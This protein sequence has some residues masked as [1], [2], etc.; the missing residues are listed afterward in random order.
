MTEANPEDRRGHVGAPPAYAP[1]VDLDRDALVSN[2][3]AA[4]RETPEGV[5]DARGGGW[6][7]GTAFVTRAAAE[8]G[9]GGVLVEPGWRP[10][11]L[12]VSEAD[13]RWGTE[14]LLDPLAV[15]GLPDD[16]GRLRGRPVMT[17]TGRV[18]LVK[19]VR[20]G[21][22]VSYGYTYRAERDVRVALV[23]GGYGQGVV[24]SIG[25]HVSV[26]IGGRDCPIVGRVAMDVA[27]VE[28]GDAAVSAGDDVLFFGDPDAGAPS[29]APWLGAS[30]L[31]AGEIVA[32][33]GRRARPDRHPAV[34]G[35][36]RPS[37][38]IDALSANIRAIQSTVA[39]AEM[40]LVVKDD[41]YRHGVNETVRRALLDGVRWI[42]AFDVTTGEEVVAIGRGRQPE[43]RVFVWSIGGADDALRATQGRMDIGIGDFA[44]LD[45]VAR[46]ALE[47][48]VVN[49]VHLKI[50]SGL[51]R[52]GFRPEEWDA[53]VRAARAWEVRGAIHVE[54]VWSHIAEASDEEDDL[55]RA[56]F[57]DAVA[58]ARTRGLTPSVRHLAASAAAF[59]R[60]EFRYD[61][62]RVGAFAYGIRSAGG[63]NEAA[64]GLT[65]VLTLFASVSRVEE[66]RVFISVGSL[67]GLPSTLGGRIEVATPGG[68]VALL[69]VGPHE[70]VVAAWAGAAR[71]DEVVIFGPTPRAGRSATDL[72]ET[73]DTIGEEIVLRTAQS[74]GTLL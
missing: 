58:H 69:E 28:I 23:T 59:A 6:G 15:F 46:A 22:G 17:L 44:H 65:P 29:L 53:A 64:L 70:S 67:D 30:G 52:N 68:P 51:H 26:R 57:D 72:A 32:T 11:T 61:M 31:T 18:L 43:P 56:A 73:I 1:R 7:H 37:F 9:A 19:Q 60:P 27:M 36:P 5:V 8:A 13:M 35:H 74:D 10:R 16:R 63:P 2:I 25:N 54:G 48:D 34:A 20:A 55:A 49:R 42:G 14:G 45:L 39:P 41:A 50:D 38:D 24:R 66:G 62:V 3:R 47:A 4:L 33:V 71:G 40:M 21:E 12:G